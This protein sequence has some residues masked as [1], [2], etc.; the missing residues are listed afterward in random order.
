MA[1]LVL[2]LRASCICIVIVFFA[3][4]SQLVNSDTGPG[5]D[6]R[7][8]LWHS[9]D[10]RGQVSGYCLP[11]IHQ[12]PLSILLSLFIPITVTDTAAAPYCQCHF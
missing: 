4:F 11:L 6:L 7:N 9:G 8:A 5:F 3:S 2:K 10:V 12:E 1:N